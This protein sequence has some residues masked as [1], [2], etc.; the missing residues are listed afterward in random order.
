MEP[1]FPNCPV[2]SNEKLSNPAGTMEDLQR[3]NLPGL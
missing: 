3:Q 2:L 1:I